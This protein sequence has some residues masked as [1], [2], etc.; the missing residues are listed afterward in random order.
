M[1][2][3]S[4]GPPRGRATNFYEG[5]PTEATAPLWADPSN[6]NL[7]IL[8]LRAT[9]DKALPSN[10]FVVSKTIT[11]AI[12]NFSNFNSAKPQRDEKKNLQYILTTRDEE[13]VGKL[14]QIN[15]LIDNTPVEII[16]HPTLNQ[17]KCVVT[18]RDVINITETELLKELSDQKV[19]DVKRIT[20]KVGEE[21]IPTATLIITLRGTVVPEFIYFG[22]IRAGTRNYY[23]NPMQCFKCFNFGHTS[24]RCK[25]E[26]PLC[27]NCSK[28][29][30]KDFD[31]KLCNTPALCINCQGNHSSSS[32]KC[33]VW[34]K[35]NE[36]TKIRIDRGISYKE[37]KIISNTQNG[38]TYSSVLQDR[39]NIR[40]PVAGCKCKCSC[41]SAVSAASSRESTPSIIDT[42]MT[43][44]STESST[45]ES[46]SES[47]QQHQQQHTSNK[48]QQQQGTFH[49]KQHTH[50]KLSKYLYTK[51]ERYQYLEESFSFQGKRKSHPLASELQAITQRQQ[52]NKMAKSIF[53]A[54][55]DVAV[56]MDNETYL[57]LD[58]N[59]RQGSPTKEY[60]S[61]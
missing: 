48:K 42:T 18:C 51:Q 5:K 43:E 28:E 3:S 58:G 60:Y 27:R 29:H 11:S 4:S 19:I 23:P 25:R 47:K 8:L 41:A 22:F 44:S 54:N 61:T 1:A 13:S 24:K 21:I 16:F 38:P 45:T 30:P 46:D 33:P 9:G 56:V 53:S 39:L 52:V 10:P 37:A 31:F 40:E 20:R 36:I 50:N 7:Q 2:S 15:K 34:L 57:T 26:N 55:R 59:D 35:E 6:G 12:K 49:K 32:R 14:L 17:R